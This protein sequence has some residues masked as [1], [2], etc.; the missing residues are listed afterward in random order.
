LRDEDSVFKRRSTKSGKTKSRREGFQREGF[1]TDNFEAEIVESSL[2][3][4]RKQAASSPSGE[5]KPTAADMKSM[6]ESLHNSRVLI[7]DDD[8][9]NRDVVEILLKPVGIDCF[10]VESG[11]D[12]LN[13]MEAYYF[14]VV[15]M[16]IRMPDMSGTEAIRQIRR[17]GQAWANVPVI[18]LTADIAAENNAACMAAGADIFLTKPILAKDLLEAICFVKFQDKRSSAMSDIILE[19]NELDQPAID[20]AQ[21]A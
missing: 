4:V 17:S 5:I 2:P 12:A 14:D 13:M 10:A 7:V 18:A 20:T 3:S 16:D 1:E 8:A 6:M 11:A 19:L 21:S 9:S 15:I